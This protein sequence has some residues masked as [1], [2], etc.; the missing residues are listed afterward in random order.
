MIDKKDL[1]DKKLQLEQDISDLL[2]R[3]ERETEFPV[4]DIRVSVDE[5]YRDH[6][7]RKVKVSLIV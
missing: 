5:M 6:V 1:L 2:L 7:V 3:F 4:S